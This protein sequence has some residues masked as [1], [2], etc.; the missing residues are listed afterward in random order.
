MNESSEKEQ[1]P[2]GFGV[3]NCSQWLVV[4][5]DDEVMGEPVLRIVDSQ[6]AAE[7]YRERLVSKGL[8]DLGMRVEIYRMVPANATAQATRTAPQDDEN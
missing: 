3:S 8:A 7:R 5:R 2:H 1:P 6:S 4:I